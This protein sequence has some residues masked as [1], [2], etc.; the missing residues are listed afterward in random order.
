MRVEKEKSQ[1][2]ESEGWE[3][4]QQSGA[5]MQVRDSRCLRVFT[6]ALLWCYLVKHWGQDEAADPVG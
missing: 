2:G 1:K 6:Y 4:E 3:R 5:K